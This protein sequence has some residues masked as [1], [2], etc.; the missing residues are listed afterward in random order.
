MLLRDTCY[1]TNKISLTIRQG[2]TN[3][4]LRGA[5]KSRE[6]SSTWDA[7]MRCLG[8]IPSAVLARWQLSCGIARA[9]CLMA[10]APNTAT[11]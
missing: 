10:S 2:G 3:S 6:I 7:L 4:E 11:I 5:D 1:L 8:A 9:D